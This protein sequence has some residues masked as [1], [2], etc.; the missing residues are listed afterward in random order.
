[1]RQHTPPSAA[2][3][4]RPLSNVE[5]EQ[6][7]R[8]RAGENVPVS[9]AILRSYGIEGLGSTAILP[10]PSRAAFFA[11]KITDLAALQRIALGE[12][13][14]PGAINISARILPRA[15]E[16]FNDIPM[17][18]LTE[19]ATKINA[20]AYLIENAGYVILVPYILQTSA[21]GTITQPGALPGPPGQRMIYLAASQVWNRQNEPVNN[22]SQLTDSKTHP[23][24][25]EIYGVFALIET[26]ARM[27]AE[28]LARERDLPSDIN[29]HRK[30]VATVVLTSLPGMRKAL[31]EKYP[32]LNDSIN[33]FLDSQQASLIDEI[34]SAN[35][36]LGLQED[37]F[38]LLYFGIGTFAMPAA[39]PAVSADPSGAI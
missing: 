12:R 4:L 37:D 18:S 13:G 8:L 7:F 19:P 31:T 38:S 21:D 32:R 27:E 30:A 26:A 1:M 22:V 14:L 16:I 23:V 9:A 25:L 3:S 33:A 10:I 20:H 5:K 17:V 36:A 29:S 39:V 2:Y 28:Q 15:F 24:N 11:R 34:R 6:S 35:I